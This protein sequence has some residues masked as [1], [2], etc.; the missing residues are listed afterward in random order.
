VPDWALAV[1]GLV[2]ILLLGTIV[3]TS[4]SIDAASAARE[5]QGGHEGSPAPA[6]HEEKAE[7]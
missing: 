5:H 3:R 4:L 7:K 1:M 6:G 2:L